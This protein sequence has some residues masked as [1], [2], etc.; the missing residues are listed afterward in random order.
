VP[1]EAYKLARGLGDIDAGVGGAFRERQR[2][3]RGACRRSG[4]PWT[5]TLD[6]QAKQD[7]VATQAA[8]ERTGR[9]VQRV[10]EG[11]T[12]THIA[13][14]LLKSNYDYL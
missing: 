14:D 8:V 9:Y 6:S 4:S 10:P 12:R 13:L 2:Q 3:G 1:R 5:A 7:S 11:S